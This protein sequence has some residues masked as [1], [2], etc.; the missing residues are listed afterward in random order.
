MNDCKHC[1]AESFP[2]C[3]CLTSSNSHS[4]RDLSLPLSQYATHTDFVSHVDKSATGTIFYVFIYCCT[5]SKWI[6]LITYRYYSGKC[7]IMK[8][9]CYVLHGKAFVAFTETGCIKPVYEVVG[10]Q[11]NKCIS[12]VM[13]VLTSSFP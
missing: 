8:C 3:E 1:S 10:C 7:Q 4:D 13:H 9:L 2:D 6:D 11:Q 12:V 5:Q